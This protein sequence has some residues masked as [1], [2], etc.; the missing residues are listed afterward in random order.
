VLKALPVSKINTGAARATN[1]PIVV[2][3]HRKRGRPYKKR[4]EAIGP[5]GDSTPAVDTMGGNSL[6]S[7]V[8][9]RLKPRPVGKKNTTPIDFD[10]IPPYEGLITRKLARMDKSTNPEN[11]TGGGGLCCQ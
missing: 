11:P 6:Q 4:V 5:A 10:N 7:Q 1:L 9:P 3:E 2:E 8:V